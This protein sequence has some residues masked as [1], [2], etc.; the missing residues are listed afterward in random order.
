MARTSTV[1]KLPAEIRDLIGQLKDKG[2]TLDEIVACL[3]QMLGPDDA[4]SRSALGRHLQKV[5]AIAERMRH[6]RV[7]ADTLVRQ[8]GEESTDKTTRLNI[9]LMH[10]VIFDL[11]T[12][13]QMA[14][15]EDGEPAS[16]TLDPEQVMFLAK[17]LDHLG[18]ASVADVQRIEKIE[19]R[20]AEKAKVEAAKAVDNVAKTKGLTSDTVDAIKRE[21]L[22]IRS[23]PKV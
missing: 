22:G 1:D 20:A 10:T 6:S 7:V 17:S 14:N 16:L 12:A 8:L 2:R 9:E 15:G 11:V 18:K 3:R 21:I 23:E 4:P 19:K 5:E 13:A